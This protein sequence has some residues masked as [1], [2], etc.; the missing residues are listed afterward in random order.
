MSSLTFLLFH[1]SSSL[2]LFLS[3]LFS[4]RSRKNTIVPWDLWSHSFFSQ[5]PAKIPAVVLPASVLIACVMLESIKQLCGLEPVWLYDLHSSGPTD[6]ICLSLVTSL[7]TP[8]SVMLPRTNL[9]SLEKLEG[10]RNDHLESLT[11]RDCF[12]CFFLRYFSLRM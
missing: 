6:S 9:I 4:L 11:P 12:I 2:R 7:Q 1:F 8:Y 3:N 10:I 5:T